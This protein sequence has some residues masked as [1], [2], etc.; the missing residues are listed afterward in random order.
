EEF[1]IGMAHR[2]R[3]NVLTNIMEKPYKEIFSEFEGKNYDE[4]SPF[5][6]D[7]KYHLGYSTDIVTIGGKHVHLS[8]CP[9]PSHLE[10][11]DPVVEGLTRSKIDFKYNGDDTR[12]APILIHGDASVA[13]QGIVYEV[14]QMEKLDGYRT[15]GTIHIVINNQIGFTTN[16]KD[17]RSSTYCTDV[18]KT[19]LSPV[20]HVNGDDVEALAYVVN[21]ALEYRQVFHADIFID[22]LCYRRY[23]HNEADEPKFTQPLLYKAIEAHPNPLEIYKQKLIAEGSI[24][25]AFATELEKS[26]RKQLQQKL[27]ES[28]A[29]DK[30]TETIQMFEGAWQGLHIAS[31]KEFFTPVETAVPE[32]ELLD[33][34]KKLSELPPGKEFFKKIEKL[35]EE[36]NKMVTKTHVFDW[37]MGE[38]LAYGTLLKEGH[39]VRL[40]GEDVKRGTFS[41]RHAVLTLVDSEEEFTP[42][43]TLDTEAKFTIYNSLLSEYAVL[44]FDYGYAM[45]NPNALTIWEAQFG[46]F[47]NGAQIIVDQYIASAE[48]KW[49][50]GNGLV[51]LLPHGYE[52][53]GP[54]HSSARVERFL[55]LCA[56]SNIQVA[57]CTTPANFFH[58]IRRQMLRDFRKPLIIF[59]PKSLL[60]SPKC[61][62]ALEEFTSGKFRELID[63]DY[64]DPKKVKRV[65]LC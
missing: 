38:L 39:P 27:D 64:A 23:G 13:G 52:G 35:F 29:E 7:V 31:S 59:T 34:G 19:V 16:F 40:S 49:Q 14:L 30:I 48:T 54:E 25:A 45:A 53:Q 65:L 58:I 15:G 20:F 33:I 47:F 28:K 43:D 12:I 17:A 6:G 62:S 26:F 63:D 9:N 22:I 11:V 3:L 1:I 60:R 10:A 41:H 24:D 56:D 46:D 2:G 8:L 18:A 55:E 50:R 37:A 51:M 21:L 32:A 42:L 61:V 5:G 4:D 36:R 57:N 44:G